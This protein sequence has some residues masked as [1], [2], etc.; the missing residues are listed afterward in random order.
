MQPKVALSE[1]SATRSEYAPSVARQPSPVRSIISMPDRRSKSP[2]LSRAPTS[3]GDAGNEE[4]RLWA[5]IKDLKQSRRPRNLWNRTLN[6]FVFICM[7]LSSCFPVLVYCML[8]Y[9]DPAMMTITNCDST[10]ILPNLRW[11]SNKWWVWG[12]RGRICSGYLWPGC[13]VPV[14][15]QKRALWCEV[16]DVQRLQTKGEKRWRELR[17]SRVQGR[18]LRRRW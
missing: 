15:C 5:A 3:P 12:V 16:E 10:A 17:S 2:H 18:R 7:P 13:R 1:Q 4:G 14:I 11:Q 9:Y 8:S 6:L